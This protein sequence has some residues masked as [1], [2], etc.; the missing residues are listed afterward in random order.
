V[1]PAALARRGGKGGNIREAGALIVGRL[2]TATVYVVWM[3]AAIVAMDVLF[4]RH[5]VWER[6][7]SN[8]GLV[9]LFAAFYLRLLQRG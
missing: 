3:V 1:W 5:L 8:V 4:F 6:L 7:M 2:A 9:L